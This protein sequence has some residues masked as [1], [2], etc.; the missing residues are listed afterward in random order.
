MDRSNELRDQ[1]LFHVQKCNE[2]EN[3]IEGLRETIDSLRRSRATTMDIIDTLRSTLD[4]KKRRVQMLMSTI[5][6]ERRRHET[7]M[8][9]MSEIINRHEAIID[10]LT[11]TI[12]N[13]RLATT[14]TIDQLTSR[15]V[16]LQQSCEGQM[17]LHTL[18]TLAFERRMVNRRRMVNSKFFKA[19]ARRQRN[20]VAMRAFE[21]S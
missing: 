3:I 7:N 18:A 19:E 10:Q 16:R 6:G 15:V 12:D 13:Q 8:D 17:D 9:E 2:L 4:G 20:I 14:S 11:S 5:A 21:T 1:I